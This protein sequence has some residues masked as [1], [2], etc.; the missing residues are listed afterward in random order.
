MSIFTPILNGL[1][2]KTARI[3]SKSDKNGPLLL[4]KSDELMAFLEETSQTNQKN[5][6]RLVLAQKQQT[7]RIE[8]VVEDV[9]KILDLTR[10]ETT[11]SFSLE[12]TMSLLSSLGQLG[13][14]VQSHPVA[15]S[16]LQ[17]SI[18]TIRSK[19][20]LV[21]ICKLGEPY[22]DQDCEIVGVVESLT[23]QS[24][25]IESI[26]EQGYRF[27]GGKTVKKAK[28]VVTKQG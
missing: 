27:E 25:I 16:M 24:G 18:G 3:F 15:S 26:T 8:G 17:Q 20:G 23:K 13:E 10:V 28:V 7:E 12:E 2:S 19:S 22:P 6:R 4:K 21:P 9:A 11:M 5:L 14:L 1:K